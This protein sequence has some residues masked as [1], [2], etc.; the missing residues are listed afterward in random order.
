VTENAKRG[1]EIAKWGTENAKRGTEI[2]KWGTENDHIAQRG[3]EN[4]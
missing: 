1:T 3:T 4:A 2:A